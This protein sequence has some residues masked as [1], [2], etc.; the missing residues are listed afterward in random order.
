MKTC[1]KCDIEK[2]VSQFSKSK[3]TVDGLFSWCKLCRKEYDVNRYVKIGSV[4]WT[5]LRKKR[6]K[7]L[8]VWFAEYKQT[9]KCK[10]CP[11]THPACLDFHHKD[12]STKEN[13]VSN[14]VISGASKETILN[15]I[16]K[17]DVLCAN[18]HRKH[19]FASVV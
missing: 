6:R 12:G 4:Q 11:E 15:E 9:L 1:I 13:T 17:C 8:S 3:R 5:K 2:D 16:K 14:L 7:E 18:C 19:H 10:R